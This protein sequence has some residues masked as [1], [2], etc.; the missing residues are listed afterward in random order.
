MILLSLNIRGVG[1]APKLASLCRLL[2]CSQPDIILFQETLV[3]EAKSRALVT[4]LL[5]NGYVC[6]VDHV[7]RSGGLCV[8]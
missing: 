5:P 7:G 3:N 2:S 6:V 4:N 8:A 1:G